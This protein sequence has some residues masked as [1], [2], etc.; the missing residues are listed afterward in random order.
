[1]ARSHRTLALA[2]SGLALALVSSGCVGPQGANNRSP[3][4][5]STIDGEG[6]SYMHLADAARQSGDLAGAVRLYQ[7]VLDRNPDQP[8]VLLALAE[9]ELAG[10]AV[11]DAN[12]IYARVLQL[13]PR[14]GEAHFGLG[15]A[16]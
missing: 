3:G 10:G 5:A 7:K 8:D 1:M 16:F 9:V 4:R 13:D 14:R 2:F 12:A 6:Q 15:R 11:A